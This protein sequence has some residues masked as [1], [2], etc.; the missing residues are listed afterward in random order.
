MSI[1]KL[2]L[3]IFSLNKHYICTLKFYTMIRKSAFMLLWMLACTMMFGQTK[4]ENISGL[5]QQQNGDPM[6][7]IAVQIVE[8]DKHTLTDTQ[9]RYHF[10]EIPSGAYHLK[11]QVIGAKEVQIPFSVKDEDRAVEVNYRFDKEN[12]AMIQEVRILKG[13]NKFSEKESPYVAKLPLKNLENPQVYI[14]V[15]K[16]LIQE[17]L[18]EDIGSITKNLPGAGIPMLANQ[19]RVTFLT[20]GFSTEPMVRNGISGFSYTTIDPVNLERIEAIRGPSGTLFGTNLATYGGLFNRVT[21]KPFNDFGGEI[22]YTGGSWNY[23]RFTVDVNT[24]VNA[25]KTV[26]FRLNG[27]TTFQKSFQDLGFKNNVTVAPSL[28]YQITDRL[29]ILFDI[30]YGREKGTSVVRFNPFLKSNKIQSIADMNFPYNKLFGSNDMPYETEMM[31]IFTQ[32]NYKISDQWASQTVFSRARSTIDGYTTAITGMSDTTARLQVT[33]GNTNFIA[34]NIQQNFIGDFQIA[35]HRNRLIVGMDYYNNADSFDR[36]VVNG[37]TFDFTNPADANAI[38]N[39]SYFDNQMATGTGRVQKNGDNSYA[40]YFSNVFNVTDQFLVMASLRG[41]RYQNLGVT[42][43]AKN[44]ETGAYWQT[45]FSPKLGLVYEV[46]KNKVSLFGNYM[47]GFTNVSG[48]DFSGSSFKPEQANQYE[49]GVKGDLLNHKLVG[50]VSY[51]NIQV[52]DML[53][54]DPDHADFNIQDGTRLSKG[55][56]VEFTANPFNG[57]N[58]VGGYTYNESEMTKADSSINGLRPGLS[59]PSNM[60]NLWA[61]YEIPSGN[62]K[63]LGLGFGGIKGNE[64]FH[65]NTTTAKVTIPAYTVLDA[66]LFYNHKKFRVGLKVNNLTNEKT[67]SVRLTPQNPTNVMGSI[68]FKF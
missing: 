48:S 50:T 59:G 1:K 61:S 29:S 66:S 20:R 16:A 17:Q 46:I 25:S 37:K 19:G 44:T 51:Y 63:G 55:F 21:K 40:V 8:L 23:N 36:V 12:I 49:F 18:A 39:P 30:E 41:D 57:F 53:R 14:S 45:N 64:S 67:W 38:A 7:E 65:T 2:I 9:G 22:S 27:A 4:T 47:N 62:L 68:D 58:I 56:E 15:P 43:I 60:Y 32:M 33:K 13:V 52:K 34:T 42:D 10:T 6:P 24:P 28:S 35:G 31:N 26:L 54:T 5:I 11:I 3:F